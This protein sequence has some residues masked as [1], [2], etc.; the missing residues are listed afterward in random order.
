MVMSTLVASPG[1]V[2]ADQV[3]C[4]TTKRQ[5]KSPIVMYGDEIATVVLDVTVPSKVTSHVTLSVCSRSAYPE[6]PLALPLND[7]ALAAY[8]RAGAATVPIR[9]GNL[10]M[11]IS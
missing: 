7:W 4:G 3:P 1:T 6:L 2:A 11:T 5:L 8:G 10:F 9:A